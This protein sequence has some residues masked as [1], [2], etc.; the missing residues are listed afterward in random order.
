M[1]KVFYHSFLLLVPQR[2]RDSNMVAYEFY[3]RNG[4]GEDHLIGILPERRKDPER[5]T[6]ESIMNWGRKILGDNAEVKNLYFIEVEIE[7]CQ[8]EMHLLPVVG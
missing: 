6:K 3:W 2:I 1:L 8:T 5:I 4:K 7:A